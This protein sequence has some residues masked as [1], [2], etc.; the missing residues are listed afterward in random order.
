MQACPVSPEGPVLVR[1]VDVEANDDIL[2][3]DVL[4]PKVFPSSV[5]PR[6]NGRSSQP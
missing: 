4:L 6:K 3:L 1:P 5:V 2:P